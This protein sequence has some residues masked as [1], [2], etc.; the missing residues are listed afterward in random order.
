MHVSLKVIAI[1]SDYACFSGNKYHWLRDAF[2]LEIVAIGS[3]YARF[4][5]NSSSWLTLC[6]FHSEKINLARNARVAFE[7]VGVCFDCK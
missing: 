7:M 2:S 4:C 5:C 6:A 3:D 1:G